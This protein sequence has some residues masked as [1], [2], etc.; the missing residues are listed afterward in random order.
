MVLEESAKN[1]AD[2]IKNSDTPKEFFSKLITFVKPKRG[3]ARVN[4]ASAI[5]KEYP[6]NYDNAK[7]TNENYTSTRDELAIYFQSYYNDLVGRLK[8]ISKKI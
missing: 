5:E 6:K 8:D 3:R 2:N 4:L 7:Q 1:H